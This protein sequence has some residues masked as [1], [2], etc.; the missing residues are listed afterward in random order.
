M[1][2]EEHMEE[3]PETSGRNKSPSL[4]SFGARKETI[5]NAAY[6]LEFTFLFFLNLHFANQSG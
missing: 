1:K 2:P 6:C 3:M 4:T 5:L